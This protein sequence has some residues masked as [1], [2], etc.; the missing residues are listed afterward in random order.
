ME[1]GDLGTESSRVFAEPDG[2]FTAEVSA[3]P[4]R[5]RGGA[6]WLPVD[7]TLRTSGAAGPPA[8]LALVDRALAV[9]PLLGAPLARLLG[10][11]LAAGTLSAA[12]AQAFTAYVKT[13]RHRYDLDKDRAQARSSV[14]L[15]R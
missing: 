3:R 9:G 14:H 11:V 15:G 13:V 2:T 8:V 5:V 12:H 4:T 10:R 6:G 7:T 1:A